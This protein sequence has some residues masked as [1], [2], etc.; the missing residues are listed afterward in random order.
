MGSQTLTHRVLLG[1]RVKKQ[2]FPLSVVLGTMEEVA[3]FHP[4]IASISHLYPFFSVFAMSLYHLYYYLPNLF[5]YIGSLKKQT[6]NTNYNNFKEK[7]LKWKPVPHGIRKG[8]HKSKHKE[9]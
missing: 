8:D 2:D 7:Y 9:S 6:K 1:K 3:Q 5:L 4:M